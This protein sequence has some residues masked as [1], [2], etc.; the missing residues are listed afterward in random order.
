M[1]R[2]SVSRVFAMARP[3]RPQNERAAIQRAAEEIGATGSKRA[4]AAAVAEKVARL[5]VDEFELDDLGASMARMKTT[6]ETPALAAL[7][8]DQDAVAPAMVSS[9]AQAAFQRR[10]CR[11]AEKSEWP[12]INAAVHVAVTVRLA[13]RYRRA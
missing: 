6:I 8:F 1:A 9:E 13:E 3:R 4:V 5:L 12:R 11:H 7:A 2:V 10:G